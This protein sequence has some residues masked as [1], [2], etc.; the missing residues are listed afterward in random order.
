[1]DRGDVI[2]F[3]PAAPT[4]TKRL[5]LRLSNVISMLVGQGSELRGRLKTT[6]R[7]IRPATC[8]RYVNARPCR[9]FTTCITIAACRTT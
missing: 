6:T 3:M 4:A 8:C 5:H 9:W 7:L 2:I 1:M